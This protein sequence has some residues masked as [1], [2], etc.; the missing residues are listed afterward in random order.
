MT[1]CN[2]SGVKEIGR[3]EMHPIFCHHDKIRMYQPYSTTS[4][5]K[6][7]IRPI[8]SIPALLSRLMKRD[9]NLT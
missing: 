9:E 1:Q 4:G 5:L 8:G 6:Q 3:Y 7:T 2:G